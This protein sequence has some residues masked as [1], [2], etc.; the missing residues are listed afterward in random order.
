[1]SLT[2]AIAWVEH[3]TSNKLFTM[4]RDMEYIDKVEDAGNVLL[5]ELRRLQAEQRFDAATSR[6]D[7]A[8]IVRLESLVANLTARL[9]EKTD[10]YLRQRDECFA[11][12]EA[13]KEEKR[14]ADNAEDN[15]NHLRM[16]KIQSDVER[17]SIERNVAQNRVHE[18]EAER[19]ALKAEVGRLSRERGAAIEAAWEPKEDIPNG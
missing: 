7:R 18:L 9:D 8:E 1:M 17:L 12:I 4:I 6:E 15:I 10:D 2:E 3:F 5:R 11:W 13:W 16:P 14:R 19:D